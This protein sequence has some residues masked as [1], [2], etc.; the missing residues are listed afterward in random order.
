MTTEDKALI[1]SV[2]SIFLSSLSII[3]NIISHFL[4]NKI[5]LKVRIY[6]GEEVINKDG[7]KSAIVAGSEIIESGNKRIIQPQK[8]FFKVTNA[9]KKDVEVDR[10]VV[11]YKKD[12]I[13]IVPI[14]KNKYLKPFGGF[15]SDLKDNTELIEK[16]KKH[17]VKNI[18]LKDTT[19][20]RWN[21]P[22]RDIREISYLLNIVSYNKF[23]KIFWNR[24][25]RYIG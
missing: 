5:K 14:I 13:M 1:I 8:L 11:R 24:I 19:E 4:V 7:G 22:K 25:R 6:I 18:F 20:G 10:L 16:F 23:Y 12:S 3:W 15:T 21:V 9:G 2:I 17:I